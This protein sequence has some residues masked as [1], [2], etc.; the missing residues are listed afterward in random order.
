[1]IRLKEKL[2]EVAESPQQSKVLIM[3]KVDPKQGIPKKNKT[4]SASLYIKMIII[5]DSSASTMNET[6]SAYTNPDITIKSDVGIGL[7]NLKK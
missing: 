6:V 3:A 1:M 2:S 5:P 4:P 7:I